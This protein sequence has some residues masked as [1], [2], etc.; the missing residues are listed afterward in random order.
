MQSGNIAHEIIE[1][2]TGYTSCSIHINTFK[3]LHNLCMIRY[4]KIRYCR[5]AVFLYFHI[6]R[7]IFTN[8]NRRIDN[9]RNGHHILLDLLTKFIFCFFQFSKTGRISGNFSL[10]C[11][12]FLLLTL[13]HQCTDLF[14]Y[15]IA[16][17]TDLI[18]FLLC[19]A[20]ACI[21]FDHFIHQIKLT[22]LKFFSDIF[23]YNIRI[24]SQKFNINHFSPHFCARLLSVFCNSDI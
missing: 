7:V 4:L 21:Q 11:L 19:F 16:V 12:R 5:L 13:C 9:I 24:L 23:L 1:P 22:I 17:S 8:W 14:G 2:V 3:F 18:R 6:F 15:L 10:L 20:H